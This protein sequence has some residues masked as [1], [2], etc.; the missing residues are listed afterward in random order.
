MQAITIAAAT[1]GQAVPVTTPCTTL[2]T[3]S[4]AGMGSR[5]GASIP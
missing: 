3:I 5:Y 4:A 2:A 1:N